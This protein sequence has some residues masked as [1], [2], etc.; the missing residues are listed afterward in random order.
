MTIGRWQTQGAG[1]LGAV[2]GLALVFGVI[3]KLNN[4]GATFLDTQLHEV[5]ALLVPEA[6]A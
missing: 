4:A 2:L 6:D 3:W 5:D 1:A